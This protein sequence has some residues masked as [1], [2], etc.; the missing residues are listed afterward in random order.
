M[1]SREERVRLA[2]E[3]MVAPYT[4]DETL[5]FF[6]PQENVEGLDHPQVRAVHQT[7]LTA[8]E[9]PIRGSKAVMLILPCTKVKPYCLSAEHQAIN[10]SLLQQGFRPVGPAD[11]P[12][13]IEA[14]L[15][16]GT[17]PLILNNGIWARGSLLLHRYVMSEPMALVPYEFIYYFQGQLS[18][19]ARYDDPGLFEHRGTAVSPWRADF[20][21]ISTSGGYRWGDNEKA[22]FVEMHNRLVELMVVM[23]DRFGAA[24]VARLAYV[25]PKLT[26]RSFVTSVE[27]KRRAGL[28]LGRRTANG[29]LRLVGINDRRPGR[30]RAIPDETDIPLILERLARR[31][32]GYTPTQVK[33]YFAT[34]GSGVTPLILPETLAVLAERLDQVESAKEFKEGF[35]G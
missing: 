22:A 1:W 13:E 31:L 34:G 19:C 15:L 16:P 9:P 25:S 17:D 30:I 32:P 11:Y 24:Y 8:Y 12:R 5:T 27:E 29:F 3:K 23:M 7:M 10:T 28:P 4:L 21:G 6:S 20:T 35:N 18:P 2:R 33:G 14:A 26:H